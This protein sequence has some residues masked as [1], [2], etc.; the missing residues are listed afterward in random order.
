MDTYTI[1][2]E[3][4]H[5]YGDRMVS[6]NREACRRLYLRA[7]SRFNG[8]ELEKYIRRLQDHAAA[9]A[10]ISHVLQSPFRHIQTPLFLSSLVLLVAS[11]VMVLNGATTPLVAGGISAGTLGMFNCARKLCNYWLEYSIREAVFRE[12]VDNLRTEGR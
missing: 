7:V 8:A 11:F 3:M 12:L 2:I 10:S 1:D 5:Y 6:S 4:E 9:Y